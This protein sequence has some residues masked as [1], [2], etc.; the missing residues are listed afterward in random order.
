MRAFRLVLLPLAIC[1]NACGD[2]DS[3]STGPGS[4]GSGGVVTGGGG[5]GV[6]GDD[7]G[8]QGGAAVGPTPEEIL[9][10][11]WQLLEAAPTINGKQD[12]L[13]FLTPDL[14]Y[15]VNGLGHIYRTVDG[16]ASWTD[17]VDQP[18]TYFRAI[19]FVDEQRGFAGNI[20][21]GYFPGVTDPTPLYGTEDGGETWEPVSIAGPE[22]G[23]ICNFHKIDDQHLVGV[24]RVG[25]PAFLIKTSDAGATWTSL[26]LN[27]EIAMLIDARFTT[28]DRGII[29]GNDSLSPSSHTL[30]LST[31][32][33]GQTWTERYKSGQGGELA[34]K[35]SFPS[36]EVGYVSVLRQ[37]PGAVVLKTI[38]GGESWE[39]LPLSVE[40]YAAKGIGFITDE[41]GWVG[42]EGPGKP[43]YRTSDGGLTWEAD[44]SLGP[45]INR[46][47]FIDPWTGYAIGQSIH[48]LSIAH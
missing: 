8:G 17:L 40:A 11:S 28:P 38:D 10:A 47:R 45:Y 30:I 15:S 19:V 34:W 7:A 24:G 6:G 33:G 27:A 22:I 44:P 14:G 16:G 39:R 37:A 13:Y 36:P 46:F 29:V 31:E 48:K 3:S 35:I 18:G 20:G 41:I 4:G 5:Q 12:D 42:G 9:A 21:P 26:D 32:D 25:G 43:V 23:G 1:S 2:D